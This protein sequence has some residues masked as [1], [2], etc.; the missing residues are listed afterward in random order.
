M[1]ITYYELNVQKEQNNTKLNSVRDKTSTVFFVSSH[2]HLSNDNKKNGKVNKQTWKSYLLFV[3]N[4]H[5]AQ[6][7]QEEYGWKRESTTKYIA[8]YQ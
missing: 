4:R 7:Y 2:K 6:Q 5:F 3:T 1:T 8:T